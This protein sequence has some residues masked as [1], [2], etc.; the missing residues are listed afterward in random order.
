MSLRAALHKPR[1]LF[2]KLRRDADLLREAVTSD[3]F[4]NFVVTAHSLNDWVKNDSS[5]PQ[6]AKNSLGNHRRDLLLRTCRDV[7]NAC[8]HFE[9]DAANQARAVTASVSSQ[10]GFGVGRY[11]AG[12]YG[13]GEE[14]IRLALRNGRRFNVLEFS[15]QV[16]SI[17]L[18]F[19]SKH[20]V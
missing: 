9:L 6:S 19:L 18:A 14:S 3:R 20:G 10:S 12:A 13:K 7:A 2:E 1:D 8:K 15:E 5:V 17:W 4:F 16:V 11:G